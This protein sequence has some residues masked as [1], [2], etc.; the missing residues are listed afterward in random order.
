MARRLQ[1]VCVVVTLAASAGLAGEADA[2]SGSRSFFGMF[3][4]TAPAA[5]APVAPLAYADP[6]A[7]RTQPVAPMGGATTAIT[8]TP[9]P[10]APQPPAETAFCV[11]LCD[12]R[13]FPLTSGG[14][15][16]EAKTCGSLCPTSRTRVFR[17]AGI[18]TAIAAEGGAR[19]AS[20][21][22]AFLYRK[23]VV[24]GCTCN[25]KTAFGLASPSIT[26]DPTLRPG[27]IVATVHGLKVFRGGVSS[28]HK[29]ADFT[30]VKRTSVPE[31]VRRKLV[32]LRVVKN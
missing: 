10:E 13:Y 20:L 15:D 19:Y 30:P 16:G 21:A 28:R 26:S 31:D 1:I 27:D 18:D 14:I 3:G 6:A 7:P 4:A 23:Q 9:A 5:S 17:G 22:N 29:T 2:Q 12:G 32:G 24:D 25:G 8:V 11:R